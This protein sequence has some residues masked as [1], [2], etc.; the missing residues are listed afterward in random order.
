MGWFR[1]DF[2]L[3]DLP[4]WAE[5]TIR[6][7]TILDLTGWTLDQIE[8]AP[9]VILDRLLTVHYAKSRAQASKQEE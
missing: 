2:E 5:E 6:L 4:E 3:S 8:A 1:G 7:H 9:A